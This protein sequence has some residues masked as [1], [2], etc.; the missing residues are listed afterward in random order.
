MVV[1]WGMAMPIRALLFFFKPFLPASLL[2]DGVLLVPVLNQPNIAVIIIASLGKII[3]SGVIALL[4]C[5]LQRS[6]HF[7]YQ[8]LGIST[9][10]LFFVAMVVDFGI[11][12]LV[13]ILSRLLV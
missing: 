13:L 6:G 12:I 4:Y 10:R 8:N 1:A 9:S 3:S 7:Y 11:W 2:I 5:A